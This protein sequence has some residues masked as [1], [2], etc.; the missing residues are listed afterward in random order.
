MKPYP[1]GLRVQYSASGPAAG[2]LVFLHDSLG[3]I[4][5]WRDFPDR[6][7][8]ATGCALLVYDR[9]GYGRSPD[10]SPNDTRDTTYLE[11]E[12]D[13]LE[14]LLEAYGISDALLFGHSDGASIAL[15]AAAKYPAR[16][17]AVISE[18]AHIFVEE[19]TLSGVRAA[20]QAY[21]TTN[22]RER[23]Q[24][25]HGTKTDALFSAWTDTWLSDAYRHWSI[26][27]L[28]PR[29]QC[30]VLVIQGTQDEYGTLA[31]VEGIV[32]G[33]G[34]PVQRF[35]IPETGHTPHKEAATAV[36]DRSAAFIRE[37]LSERH[38]NPAMPGPAG[39]SD[40]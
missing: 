37:C 1:T 40:P 32:N 34:G 17:Q 6:L 30:P 28:L 4:T 5:L 10:F 8:A 25:Y 26:E 19:E 35:V 39:R 13:V 38:L 36:L 2:T 22:L 20:V 3:C 33:S 16:I 31:Q 27:P 11:K 29:I 7:A 12:A 18:A 23:L 21:R 14:R 15:I 24:R 9:L